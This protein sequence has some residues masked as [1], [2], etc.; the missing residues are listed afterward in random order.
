MKKLANLIIIFLTVLSIFLF[1]QV[2]A[3]DY[4]DNIK[5][6]N[7]SLDITN[8]L[9]SEAGKLGIN[10]SFFP[11]TDERQLV[12][13]E[14]IPKGKVSDPS[15]YFHFDRTGNLK[16]QVFSNITTDFLLKKI[17]YVDMN[18]LAPEI[19][20]SDYTKPSNFTDSN[21]FK[22][23]NKAQQLASTSDS[24]E[25]LYR[26]AE[27]VKNS[28]T[29]DL[30]HTDLKKASEILDE[31]TGV[32][33]HYTILF[34]ALSRSLGFPTKYVSGI[35]Y[36]TRSNS[37]EEHAWSEVW[38]PE[39][40]WTP[41]DTTFGQYG[42][43]DSYHV[44]LKKGMD[45]GEPSV[46]YSYVGGY[47]QP[48]PIETEAKILNQEGFVKLNIDFKGELL[49]Q[50]VSQQSYVPLKITVTNNE[51]YYLALPVR[52]SVA[53]EV[54]GRFQKILLLKPGEQIDTYFMI[55]IPYK[56][57]CKR[58]CTS[59]IEVLDIFNDSIETNISFSDNNDRVSL[60][61][62]IQLINSTGQVN[63]D[64]LNSDIDFY[65]RPEK[66]SY[67]EDE[68]RRAICNIKTQKEETL[69]ICYKSQCIE[70]H[71]NKDELV[72]LEPINIS[73]NET[74]VCLTLID[75]NL[76]LNS[77]LEFPVQK[78]RNI[79]IIIKNFFVSLYKKIFNL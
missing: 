49:K 26:L 65:C 39:I 16:I 47:I 11:R 1:V 31:K 76:S 51:D 63:Q 37:F 77:C 18:T 25:N 6:Q 73:S 7:I 15:I 52:V 74:N 42:W 35:A 40:G 17:P 69:R 46:V 14:T 57:E 21:N 62:A 12:S 72:E 48:D 61:E 5:Q 66:S 32:C 30:N 68:E 59:K 9:Y 45:A 55:Y 8:T 44:A 71:F 60:E 13:L 53:P 78:E 27:Y 54:Y 20:R 50:E 38:L 34:N 67:T 56:S 75:S 58:G 43:I 29:Y 64:D 3:T 41:F 4:Y 22:I 24:F 79:F 23:K 10:L 28:M 33:A 19:T 36:S 2:Q 70:R